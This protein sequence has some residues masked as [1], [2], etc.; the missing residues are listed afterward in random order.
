MSSNKT[1]ILEHLGQKY[2]DGEFAGG[3]VL[4]DDIVQAIDDLGSTLSK[5]NPANFLKDLIRKRSVNEN[6]PQSLKDQRVTARQRYGYKRVLQF[7]KYPADQDE[8]FVDEFGR[9]DATAVY[10]IQTVSLPYLARKL[11]RTEETWL[12]QIAVNLK[13][14][15]T[16]LALFAK[17]QIKDRLREVSHLQ[18]GVKTQPE[19]DGAFVAALDAPDGGSEHMYVTCEVK[20]RDERILPDQIRE[21]VAKAFEL[22]ASIA[23]PRV[24]FVKPFAMQAIEL[25]DS[26]PCTGN[27]IYVVEF[28]EISREQFESMRNEAD[29]EWLYSLPLTIASSVVYILRPKVAALG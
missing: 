22:T 5:R 29:E 21:Q 2:L 13:L 4:S 27:G 17:P 1:P 7:Y 3:V 26:D 20:Q 12:T 28:D 15:E 19:I 9:S 8:P 16:Q 6:W 18:T 10:E 11:G 14:V 25:Q 23:D 24:D